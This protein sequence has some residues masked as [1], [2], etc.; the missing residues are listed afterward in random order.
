MNDLKNDTIN[1]G[2]VIA[3]TDEYVQVLN[4]FGSELKENN[5]AGLTSHTVSLKGE[6]SDIVLRTVCSGIGKVNA[7]AAAALI[8]DESDIIINAGLSGGFTAA[9]KYDLVVGTEFIE[10]D[11]DL[12]AIGYAPS[13]KPGNEGRLYADSKLNSDIIKKFPFVKSGTFVTGDSFICTK[14]RH[15]ALSEMFNPIACDMESAAVAHAAALFGKPFVSIRLIS[16]GAND[17]STGN[18]S[19]TLH[20]DR[21]GSWLALTVA[22]LK[23]L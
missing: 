4:T 23:T 20:C 8:A 14:E 9:E 13:V 7:A 15:D 19:D 6:K 12:T 2:L 18:Y 17:D 21:A 11:F 5:I 3:D 22:W 1:I 16:D 10:H